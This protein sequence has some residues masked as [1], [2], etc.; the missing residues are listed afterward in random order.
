MSINTLDEGFRKDMDRGSSIEDRLRTLQ[1]F[2]ENGIETV[3]F[4]SPCFPGI[5]D[6]KAIIEESVVFIDEY[7]FENLNLRG[8]YKQRVLAY[9]HEKYPQLDNLY[10]RIYKEGDESYWLEMENAFTR[11]CDNRNIR[12]VNAFYHSK[13]VEGKVGKTK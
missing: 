7:W 12:Y 9:I 3:L 5:T 11:Y 1:V 2:H 13:L 8:D 6:F 10:Q 4:M